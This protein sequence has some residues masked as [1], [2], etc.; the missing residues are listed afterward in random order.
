MGF[1][2]NI[3]V[4]H[5]KYLILLTL[6]FFQIFFGIG[7]GIVAAGIYHVKSNNILPGVVVSG[8]QLYGLSKAEA[9]DVLGSKLPLPSAITLVW[10]DEQF[11]VPLD[12]A[13]S[14]YLLDEVIDR[15]KDLSEFTSDGFS[16]F[17]LISWSPR[18]QYLTPKLTV[19][20]AYLWHELVKIK[21]IIDREPQ[22]ARIVLE[23]NIPLLHAE[24]WGISLDVQNSRKV[25][26]EYLA[27]GETE[28]IPL[29][30]AYAEPDVI[31]EQL[32]DFSH[33][34]AVVR[35]TLDDNEP[36]RL[37][38]IELATE[39]LTELYMEPGDV[40]SFNE[41]MGQ[42]TLEKGFR[43]VLVI[44]NREFVP[45]IGGG[46]CQVATTI[47]QAA[48][49]AEL[50]IV[51]RSPH[52]RPVSYVPLG[53]DATVSYNL[54]DLKIRNNRDFPILMVGAVNEFLQFAFYGAERDE[55]IKIEISSEDIEVIPSQTL[56]QP[57]PN[58]PRDTIQIVREGQDGYKVHVFRIIYENERKIL[59]E[60]ISTDIYMPVNE[61]VR[62]GRK[63]VFLESK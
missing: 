31:G 62:V 38:N 63:Q 11:R 28:N 54:L 23:N 9:R 42:A 36:D 47:Y 19:S 57:D 29:Q 44:I 46:I 48:L 7:G 26:M 21:N 30:V 41:T 14:Q 5:R 6:I 37:H 17:N 18:E 1:W 60:L 53:Q 59:K 4:K 61:V 13:V 51:Q 33:M 35:T 34:L 45:G 16:V 15:A 10:E 3:S 2:R 27:R 20:P 12:D 32:P 40:F 49:K 58:L 52:S 50:D 56:E 25:I 24:A 55:T 43:E 39:M 8:V 22:N